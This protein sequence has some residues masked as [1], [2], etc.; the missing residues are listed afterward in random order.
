MKNS[1]AIIGMLISAIVLIGFNACKKET[2]LTSGGTLRFSTD[3]L[4][5]D[6]VFTEYASFTMELKI[7]N[8]QSQKISLSNVRLEKG[9]QSYFSLNVDGQSEI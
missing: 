1:R 2:L 4:S 5:F 3:T 9:T 6:T 8:P 7:Y